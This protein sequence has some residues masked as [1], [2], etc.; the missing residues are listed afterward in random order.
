MTVSELAKI[1]DQSPSTIS[2]ADD[3]GKDIAEK[4]GIEISPKLLNN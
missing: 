3:R 4:D 2:Y 1:F